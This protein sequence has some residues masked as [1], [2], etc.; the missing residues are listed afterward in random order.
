MYSV[1]ICIVGA[2]SLFFFLANE[3]KLF[4]SILCPALRK[5]PGKAVTPPSQQASLPPC[6]P[7]RGF[8]L[9]F[10]SYIKHVIFLYK[11]KKNLKNHANL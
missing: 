3:T 7:M 10:D 11:S 9:C 1:C 6:A 2:S 8:Y 5:H 4:P